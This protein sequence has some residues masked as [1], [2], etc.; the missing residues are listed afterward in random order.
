MNLTLFCCLVG[1]NTPFS[2]RISSSLTVD[3]LKEMIKEKQFRRLKEVQT[4][5]LELFKVSI[6]DEDGL[7][8]KLE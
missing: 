4:D 7:A 1:S 8:Q 3:E 2:V 6:P 5:E